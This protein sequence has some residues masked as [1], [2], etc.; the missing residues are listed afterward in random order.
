MQSS[1]YH[2]YVFANFLGMF[3]MILG[4]ILITRLEYYTNILRSVEWTTFGMFASGLLGL[5]L[6]LYFL[7]QH[8]EWVMKPR[9]ILTL[10]SWLVLLKGLAALILPEQMIKVYYRWVTPQR[11]MVA[12]IIYIIVGALMVFDGAHLYFLTQSIEHP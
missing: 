12:S 3:L 9:L 11:V 2:A 6:G 1:L 7:Q 8:H 4:V 10:V 5:F